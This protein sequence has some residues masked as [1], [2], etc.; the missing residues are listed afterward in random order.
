LRPKKEK[1]K[2]ELGDIK[3]SQFLH[4]STNPKS[5][6]NNNG[7]VHHSPLLNPFDSISIEVTEMDGVI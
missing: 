2:G 4:T 5:N 7:K 3:H 1:E 6:T